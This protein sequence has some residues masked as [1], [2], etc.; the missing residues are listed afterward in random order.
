MVRVRLSRSEI[1][2][3]VKLGAFPRPIKLSPRCCRWIEDEIETWIDERIA[4]DRGRTGY[5]IH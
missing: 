5:A 3:L 2:R 1:W 4:M